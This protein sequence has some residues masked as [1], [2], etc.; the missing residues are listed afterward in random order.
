VCMYACCFL[1]PSRALFLVRFHPPP[2]VC[3]LY[4]FRASKGCLAVRVHF[5]RNLL[6]NNRVY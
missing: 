3:T 5:I 2:S 4:H 1:R 6:V